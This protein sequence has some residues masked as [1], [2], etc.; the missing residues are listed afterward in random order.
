[1]QEWVTIERATIRAHDFVLARRGEEW[2]VRVDGRML[3][4]N[5]MHQSEVDLALRAIE[6]AGT[7]R[8]MLIG[9]LG[10]GYT[11]RAALDHVSSSAR[12]IVAELVPEL[13][14]WNRRHLAHLHDRALD[15]L[16]TEV[17]TGDALDTI[18]AARA[19]LDVIVLDVDNGPEPL[20]QA[21]NQRLYNDKGTR[22][23]FDALAP[24]GVLGVWSAGPNDAYAA[25]LTKAG[26]TTEVLRVA[27]RKGSG[28][29]H[30]LFFG[31]KRA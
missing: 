13:V 17:I 28:S 22:A 16:R 29:R 31:K 12:V 9:G 6:R 14:D 10:L 27:A 26:F 5:R 25:R 30:V 1:M 2:V 3:M 19:D 20:S 8:R 21:E 7:V 15:D 18:R 11:L 24:G 4:S 23:C